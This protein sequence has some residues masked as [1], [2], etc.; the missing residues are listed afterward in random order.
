MAVVVRSCLEHD[1]IHE[2]QQRHSFF[3]RI[4]SSW[5]RA[6]WGKVDASFP[7]AARYI[8]GIGHVHNYGLIQ[9]N[10]III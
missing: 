9:S 1:L 6:G 2:I 5:T 4:L 3:P 10:L 7:P 8:L